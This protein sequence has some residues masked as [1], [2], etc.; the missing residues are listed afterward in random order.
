MISFDYRILKFTLKFSLARKN[1]NKITV[2]FFL[3]LAKV[4]MGGARGD[5]DAQ[6]QNDC[7]HQQ[8]AH[9]CHGR[10]EVSKTTNRIK[11]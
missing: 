4:G 1:M 8:T 10:V 5:G 9:S 3:D 2:L 6:G 7:N 11:R